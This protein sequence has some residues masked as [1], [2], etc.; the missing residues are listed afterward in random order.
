MVLC[1]K[2]RESRSL[3]GLLNP[4]AVNLDK[5]C[6]YVVFSCCLPVSYGGLFL[7]EDENKQC[8]RR[9]ASAA[10]PLAKGRKNKNLLPGGTARSTYLARGGAAR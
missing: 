2:A 3:P 7:K 10:R 5:P 8:F 9:G 6:L 4:F 1:L